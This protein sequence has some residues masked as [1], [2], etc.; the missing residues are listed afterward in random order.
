[1][2][3]EFCTSRTA[4]LCAFSLAIRL[5][6]SRPRQRS[7]PRTSSSTSRISTVME[8]G[9]P[10][11]SA[12]STSPAAVKRAPLGAQLEADAVQAMR[13]VFEGRRQE[14]VNRPEGRG[15]GVVEEAPEPGDERL[16]TGPLGGT[17]VAEA[18]LE[19]DDAEAGVARFV[20][21]YELQDVA[22]QRIGAV[23][24]EA[25]EDAVVTEGRRAGRRRSARIARLRAL[26]S[27]TMVQYRSWQ[28]RRLSASCEP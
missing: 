14:L 7:W 6:V 8:W 22:H 25:L 21:Q 18:V 2:K 23:G 10:E 26:S 4:W 24:L 5:T 19:V 1:M 20:A 16:D 13:D 11:A 28:L 9:P 3:S 17:R 15:G 27:W 12:S